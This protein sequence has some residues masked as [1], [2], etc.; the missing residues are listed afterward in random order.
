[1]SSVCGFKP[2]PDTSKDLVRVQDKT[3]SRL[4]RQEAPTTD[5]LRPIPV[6]K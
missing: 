1:M 4:L 3:D 6:V 2:W 5:T